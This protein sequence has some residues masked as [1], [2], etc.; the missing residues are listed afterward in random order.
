[1]SIFKKL[2]RAKEVNDVE[3]ALAW[4]NDSPL[5]GTL[6]FESVQS[7]ARRTAGSHP[8]VVRN[9]ILIEGEKPLQVA[10]NL[11]I[12]ICGRDIASGSEHTYRGVLGITGAEKKKLF[13]LAAAM[14]VER[15][16]MTKDDEDF[17]RETLA[18]QIKN[19]G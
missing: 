12:N 16:Y 1:M 4:L 15:G 6:C 18:Q 13:H 8:D 14:M 9:A 11:I 17:G 5:A 2:F 19:A 3:H 7:E 10:L